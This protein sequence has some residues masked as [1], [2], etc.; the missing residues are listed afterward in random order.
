MHLRRRACTY[1]CG[2]FYIPFGMDSLP[3]TTKG[4]GKGDNEHTCHGRGWWQMMRM[5]ITSA[6]AREYWSNVTYPTRL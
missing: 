6:P 2:C 1:L 4:Y 5:S 3:Q